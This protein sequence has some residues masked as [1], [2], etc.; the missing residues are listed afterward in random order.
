MYDITFHSSTERHDKVSKKTVSLCE[1]SS[2]YN[3]FIYRT[4]GFIGEGKILA[5]WKIWKICQIKF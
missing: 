5:N 1:S 2:F 4:E 3:C